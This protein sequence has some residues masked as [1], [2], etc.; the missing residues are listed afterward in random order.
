MEYSGERTFE[1]PIIAVTTDDEYN[2]LDAEGISY[3]GLECTYIFEGAAA[4]RRRNR[5]DDGALL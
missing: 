3:D 5:S 2:R 1:I 4:G